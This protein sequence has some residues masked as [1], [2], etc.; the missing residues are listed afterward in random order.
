MLGAHFAEF[1]SNLPFDRP[2]APVHRTA[3]P[4]A[5]ATEER[6]EGESGFGRRP[7]VRPP[8]VVRSFIPQA[9]QVLTQ[10]NSMHAGIKQPP[11]PR[12]T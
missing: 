3:R 7:S 6:K 1:V 4:R 5:A 2:P 11:P 8:S 12:R 9:K 10:P